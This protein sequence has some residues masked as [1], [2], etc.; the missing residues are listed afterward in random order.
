MLAA[1]RSDEQVS[2]GGVAGHSPFAEVFL[3]ALGEQGGAI[4]SSMLHTRMLRLFT[5]REIPQTPVLAFSEEPG[6]FVFF[7]E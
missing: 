2:D 3:D 5:E 6:E 4:T 1:G 7:L